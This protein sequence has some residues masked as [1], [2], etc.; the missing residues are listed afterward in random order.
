MF[1]II[2]NKFLFNITNT[3]F[4]HRAETA[5]TIFFANAK[6]KILYDCRY[7]FFIIIKN[8]VFLQLHCG[9]YLLR[10]FSSNFF[11]QYCGHFK[12]KKNRAKPLTYDLEL[13]K[14]CQINSTISMGQLESSLNETNLYFRPRFDHHANVEIEKIL[15]IGF[16][17]K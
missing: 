1:W 2:C 10:N 4:I 17:S 14:Y 5:N 8:W 3:H 11:Q 9:N 7:K 12:I 15:K 16:R 13:P 6:I